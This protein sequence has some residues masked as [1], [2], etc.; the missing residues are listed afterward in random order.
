MPEKPIEDRVKELEASAHV[1]DVN[2]MPRG[3]RDLHPD[4]A[5]ALRAKLSATSVE[6]VPLDQQT[7]DKAKVGGKA[8]G[9]PVLE[10]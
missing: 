8:H 7:I 2:N 9:D 6:R 4:A 3:T 10:F 5:S 1:H